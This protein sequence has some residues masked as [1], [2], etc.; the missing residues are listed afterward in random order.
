MPCPGPYPAESD[1][2]F[3]PH[4]FIVLRSDREAERIV[5]SGVD[6]FSLIAVTDV[7]VVVVAG[8]GIESDGVPLETVSLGPLVFSS[9][10]PVLRVHEE[11]EHLAAPFVLLGNSPR[12]VVVDPGT[13][14]S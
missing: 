10:D 9:R 4:P 8:S 6:V 11:T 1:I 14:Y 5:H 13:N 7:L 3:D 12:V 2:E